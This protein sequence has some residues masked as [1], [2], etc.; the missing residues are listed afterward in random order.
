MFDR[1][2]GWIVL[3]KGMTPIPYKLVTIASGVARLDPWIFTIA[4]IGSRAPSGVPSNARTQSPRSSNSSPKTCGSP[5]N[6]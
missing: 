4:S 1:Y 3:I 6:P 2:G 5:T